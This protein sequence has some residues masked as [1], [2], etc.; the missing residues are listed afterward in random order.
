[1]PRKIVTTTLYR[2][3]D[4]LFQIVSDVEEYPDWPTD[5]P[6]NE[7]R[8]E[9]MEMNGSN[10]LLYAFRQDILRPPGTHARFAHL[11]SQLT[12]RLDDRVL[13]E[14]FD[15]MYKSFDDDNKRRAKLYIDGQLRNMIGQNT[16]L[17]TAKNYAEIY[18]HLLAL[19]AQLEEEN[20]EDERELNTE[21]S[22]READVTQPI[23]IDPALRE[24]LNPPH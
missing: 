24:K 12:A 16:G 8:S 1:M 11:A 17:N 14:T 4:E 18:D 2:G 23:E 15:N 3:G 10:P 13:L 6:P 5:G 19:D 20:L 9:P 7:V 22:L 21:S